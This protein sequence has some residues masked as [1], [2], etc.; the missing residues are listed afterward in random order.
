MTRVLLD[1]VVQNLHSSSAR[2]PPFQILPLPTQ[3]NSPHNPHNLTSPDSTGADSK[4]TY[5]PIQNP[6]LPHPPQILR[7]NPLL[8]VKHQLT[9]R[10]PC[11]VQALQ[12]LPDGRRVRDALLDLARCEVQLV[13]E[14]RERAFDE[15]FG[16]EVL[17][18]RGGVGR[19][20]WEVR[21]VSCM[22]RGGF[23]R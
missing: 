21:V 22:L 7:N 19:W 14:L 20:R 13:R 6:T 1:V 5:L 11:P 2:L 16:G 10:T 18:V 8:R 23:E 17:F 12:E 9:P 4:S 15:G 3:Q